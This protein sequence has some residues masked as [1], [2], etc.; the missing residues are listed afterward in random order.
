MVNANEFKML[1]WTKDVESL[2]NGGIVYTLD[3]RYILRFG[4]N[5]I[6]DFDGLSGDGE[7]DGIVVF[8]MTTETTIKSDLRC[9][10]PAAYDAVLLGSTMRN[11]LSVFGFVRETFATSEFEEMQKLP[12]YIIQMMSKWFSNEWVHLV[13]LNKGHW[14][15]NVDAFLN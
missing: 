1:E 11:E 4:G 14:R 6:S 7:L 5:D 13:T 2:F 15:V 8:D 10:V 9:P 12:L 3:K